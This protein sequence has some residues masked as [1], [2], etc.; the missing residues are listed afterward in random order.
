MRLQPR[1]VHLLPLQYRVETKF[2][3]TVLGRKVL[4]LGSDIATMRDASSDDCAA[5]L[6]GCN[7]RALG[8]ARFSSL[9][10]NA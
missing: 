5:F 9:V 6:F 7:I 2:L 4:A 1:G 8:E 10:E 3:V